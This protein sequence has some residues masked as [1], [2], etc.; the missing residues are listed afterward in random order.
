MICF[1]ATP[2]VTCSIHTRNLSALNHKTNIYYCTC[3][4]PTRTFL[5]NEENVAFI[6]REAVALFKVFDVY[7]LIT[8]VG[9]FS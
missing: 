2:P 4:I 3:S 8:Y 6:V 7:F 9:T 5:I 1:T